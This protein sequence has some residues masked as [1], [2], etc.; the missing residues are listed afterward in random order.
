MNLRVEF[1]ELKNITTV[2]DKDKDEL[3]VEINKLL[4]SLERMKNVWSGDDFDRFFN[5]VYNYIHRMKVLTEF[6]QTSSEYI[7]YSNDQYRNKDEAFSYE[8]DKEAAL[9][10]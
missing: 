6:M 1:D 3:N 2:I 5:K 10:E 7:N 9:N 8:L 4:D